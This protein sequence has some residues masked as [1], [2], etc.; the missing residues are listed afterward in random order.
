M[1][2]DF[3]NEDKDNDFIDDDDSDD[4]RDGNDFYMDMRGDPIYIPKIRAPCET[5]MQISIR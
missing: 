5:I 4:S 3:N 2:H 1:Q